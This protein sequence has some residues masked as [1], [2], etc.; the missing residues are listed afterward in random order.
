MVKIT[1][2]KLIEKKEEIETYEGNMKIKFKKIKMKNENEYYLYKSLLVNSN[3]IYDIIKDNNI[4][5]IYYNININ[6]DELIKIKDEKECVVRGHN[7]PINKRE[8]EDLFKKED[9]MCKIESKKIINGKLEDITGSGFFLKINMKDILFEKCLLT[10]NHILNEN[11]IKV[12]KV[13]IIEY[14][15]KIKSIEIT[16]DR[17]VYT[18]KELDYTCIEIFDKDNI[19]DYFTIDENLIEHSIEIYKNKEIFILQYPEGNELSFSSGIILEIKDNK[20]IH[21]SSTCDGSSGSPIMI[22]NSDNSIIG[23]HCAS[24]KSNIFNLSTNIISIFNHIKNNINQNYIISEI[25]IKEEDTNK[26][27][28]IINSYEQVKRIKNLEDEE[29]DYKNENEKEIKENCEIKIN[30]NIIPFTYYCVFKKKGIYKIKYTFK[31]KLSKTS[32]LFRDCSF[33]IKIDLSNFNTQNVTDMWGMFY[34]CSSLT[35][36]NLSNFNTQNV[37]DMGNMFYNCSSLTNINLSN[38][39]TQNV[40]DMSS[41]FYNCSSLTNINLSNFNTRN[42]TFIWEMFYGCKS[43]NERGVITND[44]N[45]LKELS[46]YIK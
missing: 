43:L 34:N 24:N 1:D 18:N 38:F 13:I 30:N 28:Q 17:K 15:N 46:K 40:T 6:L 21:N 42:V 20:I 32:C 23:L 33:L 5:Y 25:Q 12:N 36:I 37:T 35:N 7:K 31:N 10:N 9:A 44:M 19:K 27:F 11:D 39:K 2:I 45:I 3:K 4:I 8:I 41:M 16:E 29:D 14:K 26:E 22:R